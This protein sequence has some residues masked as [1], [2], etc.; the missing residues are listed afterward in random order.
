MGGQVKR[1]LFRASG[2]QGGLCVAKIYKATTPT[3]KINMNDSGRYVAT[4]TV[5]IS[6]GPARTGVFVFT[7]SNHYN[8]G[9]AV[10]ISIDPHANPVEVNATCVWEYNVL[11]V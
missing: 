5:T 9:D 8:A 3:Q 4:S 6:A 10:G 7:G 11:G 2:S 1:V